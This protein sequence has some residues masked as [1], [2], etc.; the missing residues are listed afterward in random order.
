M[1]RVIKGLFAAAAGVY[2][3]YFAQVQVYAED[4]TLNS[5]SM[6]A[7][8]SLKSIYGYMKSQECEILEIKV[9]RD[10]VVIGPRFIYTDKANGHI[11]ELWE[12]DYIKN[13]LLGKRKKYYL[14]D[15]GGDLRIVGTT[16]HYT[17]HLPG[18]GEIFRV[19]GLATGTLDGNS[20]CRK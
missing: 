3:G 8:I 18:Y 2:L 16:T 14:Q 10:S 5:T 20:H 17:E 11:K 7:P 4:N 9:G 13:P 12:I 19:L 1:N 6:P 15:D